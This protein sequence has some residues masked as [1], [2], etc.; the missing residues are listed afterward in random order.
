MNLFKQL[1]RYGGLV[2]LLLFLSSCSSKTKESDSLDMPSALSD[3]DKAAL[4]KEAP[5]P[6]QYQKPSYMVDV[7]TKEDL[8]L[9]ADDVALK[10]GASIR[11]TVGPQ[12]L[13]S[14]MKQLASLKNMNMSWS[15]DVDQN[16]LVDVDIK[17]GDD[18]FLSVENLLRQV[19]YF[20]DIQGST[21]I[22]KYKETKQYQIA[23]PF[24]KQTFETGTGGNV[25]GS[26]ETAANIEGTIRLDS[27]GNKFNIWENIE[28]NLNT[29]LN[30]WTTEAIT[31]ISKDQAYDRE[32][33]ASNYSRSNKKDGSQKEGAAWE[34]DARNRS[35]NYSGKFTAATRRRSG[36]DNVYLIDKPVGIITVTAPRPLQ[37]KVELYISSLKKALYRQI[38]IEAK[39]IEV[40][41][42]ST[43]SIGINWSDVLKNFDLSGSIEFGSSGQIWPYIFSNTN[44]YN[45]GTNHGRTYDPTS[46]VSNIS[47]STANFD[48]F[49][50]ALNEQGD[51]KVLSNPKISVLNGQPALITVGRNITYIDTID[52]D[53]DSDSGL[54][55]YSVNTERILSGVGLAL[56]ANILGD[57]E[58]I[59]NLVPVTSEL[60]EPIEYKTI[61]SLGAQV[62]LPI[63]NVREISSTVKVR[64]GGMLVLGGLIT[65]TNDDSSEFMPLLGDIPIVKYLFG[66]E[67]KVKKKRELIILLRPRIL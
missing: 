15:S 54:I 38:S 7:Q 20:Y 49:L 6:V 42:E 45:D 59:M 8:D 63:V 29:I 39:I 13:V 62:G 57:D 18:F 28:N 23:M 55:T 53:Y 37:E 58:I 31:T 19:D 10:V 3:E 14:I 61:G 5:L 32:D 9:P 1:L 65:S 33:N 40:T 48:I 52:S 66:Y 50:N 56:T 27:K 24:T 17:A 60:E 21:I 16:V 2:L 30:V 22:V 4:N 67:E 43:S 36:N 35:E 64:N 34:K 47:L 46:F 11:S 12:P 51:T 41:L 25:L 26:K 44:S